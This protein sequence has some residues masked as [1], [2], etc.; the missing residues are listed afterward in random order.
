MIIVFQKI[1]RQGEM[2]MADGMLFPEVLENADDMRIY[3]RI[4]E[5]LDEWDEAKA[6]VLSN[7]RP[8]LRGR[9]MLYMDNDVHSKRQSEAEAETRLRPVYRRAEDYFDP[10]TEDNFARQAADSFMSCREKGIT[11]ICELLGQLSAETRERKSE[12][13]AEILSKMDIEAMRENAFETAWQESED[14]YYGMSVFETFSDLI[15]YTDA[16]HDPAGL[17][18]KRDYWYDI[19]DAFNHIQSELRELQEKYEE[20]VTDCLNAEVTGDVVSLLNELVGRKP[21]KSET[22]ENGSFWFRLGGGNLYNR[23]KDV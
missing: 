4:N 6:L 11:E 15:R 9:S 16:E 7:L 14:S 12:K 10:R 21:K 19:T 18:G 1:S 13:I 5:I 22:T 20:N 17:F 23:Q 2:N 3:K 8:A